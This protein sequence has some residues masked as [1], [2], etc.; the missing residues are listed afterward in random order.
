MVDVGVFVAG[1]EVEVSVDAVGGE[2]WV[3][4]STIVRRTF[5]GGG[6]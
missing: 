1:W 4:A 5:D 6:L 2:Y 3:A